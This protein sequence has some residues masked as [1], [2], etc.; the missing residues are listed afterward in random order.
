MKKIITPI[1]LSTLLFS[2]F[3]FSNSQ[4]EAATV[5]ASAT[6]N[7]YSTINTSM[8]GDTLKVALYNIIKGHT[9]YEYSSLEVAMK[10]TDRDYTLSP[11][12]EN[13]PE[14]YDPYMKL[15]YADYN[16]DPSTAKTWKTSQ[17]S[18]GVEKGY[19]WNKEHIWAKSNGF[20]NSGSC[21]AYSDLHHLRASDWKCNNTRGNFPFANVSNHSSSTA[22]YDWTGNRKTDN[23]FSGSVFEPRDSDKG[24][25]ARALFYMATRYYNGDGSNSTHLTL[26]TGTDSSGGKWGYLDTLLAWHELDPVDEFE[27]HRN[28]LVYT[29]QNNR[30]PYIDHPEYARA[31]FKNE[32]I[33]VP[34]V[35]TDLTYTGTPTKTSYKEGESFD[36]TGL[37]VTA[38]FKKEDTSTYTKDV[39]NHIVWTPS[40]LTKTTTSVT[41]SYT[42]NEVSK[43]ITVNGLTVTALDSIRIEGTPTKTEYEEGEIFAPA[44][45]KVY[46]TYGQEEV[47]VTSSA[48]WST[49]PLVKGQ[50]SVTVTYGGLQQIY[51]GITVK[52]KSVTVSSIVFE[53]VSKDGTGAIGIS[54]VEKKMTSGSDICNITDTENIYAGTTGLKFASGKKGGSLTITLKSST[55]VNKL[56]VKA[57]KY[58]SDST[59]VTVATNG[60]TSSSFVPTSELESYEISIAKAISTITI[61]SPSGQRFYLKS[62]DVVTGSG[63]QTDHLKEWG[64]NYLHIGD[65]S[66]IGEGTGLCISNNLYKNAKE[67]LL[68]LEASESG[69]ISKLQSDT[70]YTNEYERYL[71]WAHA[72]KD[73]SPFENDYS[74]LNNNGIFP[75]VFKNNSFIFIAVIIIIA[76]ISLTVIIPV[77]YTKKHK[78]K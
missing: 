2:T 64:V 67:A 29:I 18:Y 28:D 6:T 69:T 16:G 17:G 77:I 55:Q 34:D 11:L 65:A 32:P 41:G 45:L 76:S 74:F 26:T 25:V 22:S 63:E 71:A 59:T 21:P 15:L 3:I 53:D 46:A 40:P 24:D 36:S 1:L 14:D 12:Q 37:T 4:K 39:T 38:T 60:P 7:Y 62:I 43:T 33:Q 23:Y 35:L 52:E 9:K 19:V 27:A 50:T 47:E 78:R 30:N 58:S 48:S 68:A 44:G 8:K 73:Y 49:T 13:E 72:N 20:G 75:Q 57:K 51:T 61:S 5:E 66:F 31:V 10:I 56:I 70:K 54:D 42:N